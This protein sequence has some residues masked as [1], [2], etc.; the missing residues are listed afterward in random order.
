MA[1]RFRPERAMGDGAAQ[2]GAPRTRDC[3]L[4]LEDGVVEAIEVPGRRWAVGVQWHPE[5]RTDPGIRERYAPLF[6]A[7][8]NASYCPSPVEVASYTSP[9]I[10]MLRVEMGFRL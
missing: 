4:E 10:S 3:R 9:S 6:T 5:H 7:F 2:L 1:T 8:I